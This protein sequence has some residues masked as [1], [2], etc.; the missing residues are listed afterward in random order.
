MQIITP[1]NKLVARECT[2]LDYSRILSES[3]EMLELCNKE[4]GK[5][6][7]AFAVAHNQV[8]SEDPLR[9]FVLGAGVI[10]INPTLVRSGG[11]IKTEK[12]GCISYPEKDPIDIQRTYKCEVKF[13]HMY[14]DG[15]VGY[16]IT[17]NMK[18][19]PARVFQHMMDILDGKYIF[20]EEIVEE[21]KPRKKRTAKKREEYTS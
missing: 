15:Q 17:E 8:S 9:F 2:E 1:P 11:V 21:K 3:K 16:P 4:H 6:K 18:G 20:E 7:H 12:E 10:I 13:M 14:P 19:I 5:Y